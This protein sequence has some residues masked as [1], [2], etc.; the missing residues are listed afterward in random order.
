MHIQRAIE[1]LG[2]KPNEA[3]V[4]LA[5]L[6]LGECTVSDIAI[7]VKLPRT[8]IQSIVDKLHK[9]GLMNFYIKRRYHYWMAEN[10][11]KFLIKLKESEASIRAV[12]P[13]LSA[14]R[15]DAGGNSTSYG[16]GA[17]ADIDIS[18]FCLKNALEILFQVRLSFLEVFDILFQS[19]NSR[20]HLM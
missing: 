4:Y 8:S 1:Q 3:K 18:C 20:F 7:K 13:E 10:P 12:L 11:E 15:H 14:M 9:N 16:D 17:V 5:A 19:V 6:N 2:F